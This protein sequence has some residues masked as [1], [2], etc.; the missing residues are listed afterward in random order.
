MYIL[1]IIFSFNNLKKKSLF[2][3]K[4]IISNK[5]SKLLSGDGRHWCLAQMTL[6]EVNP[7][8]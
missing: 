6:E 7:L 3:E 4:Y 1:L 5:K 2:S 8:L